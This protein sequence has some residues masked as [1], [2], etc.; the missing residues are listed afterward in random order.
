[1]MTMTRSHIRDQVSACDYEGKA[2][3]EV[4]CGKAKWQ[5]K[6]DAAEIIRLHGK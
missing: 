1:M 5:P 6:K 3:R 4:A 2:W